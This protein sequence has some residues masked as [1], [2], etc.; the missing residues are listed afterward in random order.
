MP[1]RTATQLATALRQRHVSSAELIEAAIERIETLD[2]RINAVVVRDFE[3]ARA[4]ARL[5]DAAL[6]RGETGPLLGVPMTVKEAFNVAGLPTTWGLP[7]TSEIPAGV[8]AVAVQR[9]KA[10]GAIIL[11]KTNI[12]TLLADWQCANPVYGVTRNPWDL[13][14]TPGGSSGGGAAALAA[15]LTP[16]EFGSD[17]SASLRCPAAFCGLYAHKPSFGLVPNRGFAPPGTPMLR[18]SP[19]LDMSVVGPVARS[20]AD[21]ALALD[22]TAGADEREAVAWRLQ[23]PPPRHEALRDH[24]VF[25][26]DDH[27]QLATAQSVRGALNER[28]E[29][30]AKAGCQIGRQ[31]DRLPD[32]KA[33][34]ET[35]VPLLMAIFAADGP[36]DEG[37]P[38]HADWIRADRRRA[39]LAHQW[40]EFFDDWD[41]VLCPAMPTTALPLNPS[42]GPP[43]SIDVDGAPVPY[44]AQ[45]L[46]APLAALTGQPATVAPIGFDAAGLP[47]GAQIIGPFL[48]DRTTLAFA[49]QMEE[50]FGGF[51]AP[52]GWR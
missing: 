3:R 18:A 31:S 35:F 15:G 20:A 14:R 11:G 9:L 17:L 6:A 22:I 23:L 47:I 4:A 51:V 12:A 52:P 30:L 34:T 41:V 13:T 46:W 29:A 37:G 19:M 42:A 50:A 27:P 36:G 45:P 26:L 48:E 5:A 40:S 38:S 39:E 21:L 16:L 24:R 44:Q 33:I 10:A 43:A 1:Y 49:E 28:A 25:V 2:G 32:L 8:D 7:G